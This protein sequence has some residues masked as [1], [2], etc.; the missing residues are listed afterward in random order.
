MR[1][2]A[3][4]VARLKVASPVGTLAG[5]TRLEL[6]VPRGH[7]PGSLNAKRYVPSK[8]GA[9]A[10]LVVVLHGCSQTA[11]AY[12]HGA[13]WSELADREGFVVL[14]PEQQRGNNAN[15]CFNWFSP[16]D[17][18][19]GRGEAASIR[20][21]IAQTVEACSIDPDRIFITGLSAGGAMTSVMLAAYPE[22]FAGGAIIAGLP[23]GAAGTMPE[24]FDRM[25]GQGLACEAALT[26]AVL[27]ASGHPGP[28]P[29]ISVW[30]GTTDH[31][32]AP[33]NADALV[34]QWRG[35]HDL[36]L[37]P[38]ANASIGS[39]SH[40]QWFDSAGRVVLEDYRLSGM[41]HGVPLATHGPEALGAAGPYMLDVGLSSTLRIAERWGLSS[42][43]GALNARAEH[44]ATAA[45]ARDP[46]Q[47]QTQRLIGRGTGIQEVIEAALRRA[48]LMKLARAGSRRVLYPSSGSMGVP[49]PFGTL[50]S[51]S[52]QRLPAIHSHENK[53]GTFSLPLIPPRA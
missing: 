2:L 35:V 4:T 9:G 48:G 41:G 33:G 1:N 28:W 29:T 46:I 52:T 49:P 30:H 26:A 23:Y 27:T 12:D 38:D 18:A 5:T 6:L 20:A 3:D 8:V 25:R 51:H 39:H 47:T 53:I 32:V 16:D 36:G 22:V 40:R 50:R 44:S 13:G 37:A 31:T 15:L 43:A 14:Y 17:T 45:L 10:A 42:A 11:A 34:A 7:N 19:R 21:L 24:A